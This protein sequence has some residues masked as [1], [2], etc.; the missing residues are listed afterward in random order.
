MSRV[1]IKFFSF[2]FSHETKMCISSNLTIFSITNRNSSEVIGTSLKSHEIYSITR[3][4]KTMEV[5]YYE[6]QLKTTLYICR[7]GGWPR[8]LGLLKNDAISLNRRYRHCPL[9]IY[10]FFS[11]ALLDLFRSSL[12]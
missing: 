4:K 10:S 12:T 5:V 7:Y 1:E 2:S 3:T 8:L 6:I 9:F 11:S